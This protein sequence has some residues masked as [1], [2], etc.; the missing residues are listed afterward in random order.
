MKRIKEKVVKYGM[1]SFGLIEKKKNLK[2]QARR[3]N[4]PWGRGKASGVNLRQKCQL[5]LFVPPEQQKI[6][7]SFM[8]ITTVSTKE[9]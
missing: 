4:K 2:I 1:I 3:Q 7:Y 5:A 9:P 8:K 6:K